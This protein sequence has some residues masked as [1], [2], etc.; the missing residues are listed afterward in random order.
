M[1][2]FQANKTIKFHPKTNIEKGIKNFIDWYKEY[3]KKIMKKLLLL[4]GGLS[5]MI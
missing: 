3:Y 2:I 1:Q 5:V 4:V